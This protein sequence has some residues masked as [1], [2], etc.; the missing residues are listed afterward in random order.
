MGRAVFLEG[1]FYVFGGE[2]LDDPLADPV[3]RVYDRVDVYDPALHTWRTAAPMSTPRHGIQP[4]VFQGEVL[5]PCGG[6][7]SGW[8]FSN[9]LDRYLLP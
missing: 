4:V 2:T 5:V 3:T 7:V 6:T 9:V 8:S 1:E